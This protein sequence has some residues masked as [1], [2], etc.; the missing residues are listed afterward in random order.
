MAVKDQHPSVQV[1]ETELVDE[2]YYTDLLKMQLTNSK[3]VYFHHLF[4]LVAGWMSSY[5]NEL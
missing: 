5:E 2:T 3:W 4:V 1:K